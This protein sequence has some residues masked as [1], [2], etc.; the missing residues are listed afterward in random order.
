MT[1][2]SSRLGL[3]VATGLTAGCFNLCA[4]HRYRRT[5]FNSHLHA[6]RSVLQSRP[7]NRGTGLQLIAHG[8]RLLRVFEGTTR[9]DHV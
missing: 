4:E 3:L 9:P 7:S 1:R 2:L 6:S 5:E 8:E